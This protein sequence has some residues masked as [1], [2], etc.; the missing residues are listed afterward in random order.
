MRTAFPEASREIDGIQSKRLACSSVQELRIKHR[1]DAIQQANEEME[2][3]KRK[4]EDYVAYRYSNG[5]TGRELLIRFRYLLF[6]SADK[7]REKQ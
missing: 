6:K 3:A 5:D 4:N 7:W 1:W 2:E